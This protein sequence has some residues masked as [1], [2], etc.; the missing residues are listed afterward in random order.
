ML[1]NTQI[2]STYSLADGKE[3]SQL[4][5]SSRAAFEARIVS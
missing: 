3:I 2:Q 4:Q 1:A 5:R